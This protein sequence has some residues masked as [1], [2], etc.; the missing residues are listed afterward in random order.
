LEWPTV[1]V[2]EYVFAS[3]QFITSL[4]LFGFMHST[5][6]NKVDKFDSSKFPMGWGLKRVEKLIQDPLENPHNFT[7]LRCAATNRSPH[8]SADDDSQHQHVF[9]ERLTFLVTRGVC[10]LSGGHQL[11]KMVLALFDTVSAFLLG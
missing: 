11:L 4:S 9:S 5:K 2:V 8:W 6:N 3:I 10:L 1:L 7:P